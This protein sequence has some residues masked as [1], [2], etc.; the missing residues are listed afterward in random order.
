MRAIQVSFLLTC[1]ILIGGCNPREQGGLSSSI[2]AS[3]KS[4]VPQGQ[5]GQQEQQERERVMATKK[6]VASGEGTAGVS[7]NIPLQKVSSVQASSHAVERKIIS[8]AEMTIET[9]APSDG[10]SKIALIVA[11]HDGFVVTSESKENQGE[12]LSN[13]ATTVTIIARVPAAKFSE[14]LEEIKKIDGRIL[15]FKETGQD[16]T[17]EYIDLEA[18]LR[19]KR[20]LE[21]QFLEIMKQARKISDALEVQNELA[22]V[23]TEI[24]SLEGRRRFLENQS[25]LSTITVTLHTPL[26]IAVVTTRGFRTNI[27]AAFGDG[28]DTATSIVLGVI[29]FI[30]V[31]IPVFLLILLPAWFLF[32]WL[33]HHIP[34]PKKSEPVLSATGE[35]E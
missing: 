14:A 30:I 1:F 9:S 32:K 18:R 16:V 15:H 5:Q 33:R 13:P 28:L 8:N 20:A 27:T 29:H 2:P 12:S 3:Q 7:N 26:P 10:Q 23:R 6:E 31:M 34:W 4:T 19:T 24:E 17:E 11:K 35:T 22:S 25:A 21:M